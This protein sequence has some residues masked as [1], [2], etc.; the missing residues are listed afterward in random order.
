M[1]AIVGFGALVC[2][3]GCYRTVHQADLDAWR[4]AKVEAL[5]AHPVFAA[6]PLDKRPLSD[7]REL[8]TYRECTEKPAVVISGE[9]GTIVQPGS[10]HCCSSQFFIRG[11][12][13]EEYR[14]VGACATDESLR[15]R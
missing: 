5:E 1:R 12:L 9:Y 11:G 4:G 13:V 14:A 3:I 15:P 6:L 7:G 8:W 2:S 10:A